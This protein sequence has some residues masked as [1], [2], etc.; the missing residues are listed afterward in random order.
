MQLSKYISDLLYRYECVIVPGFGGFVSNVVS[1]K[2]NHFT[3]TFYP[4]TKK[5][6]FNSQLQTNDG[7]LANYISVAEN[8]TFEIANEKINALVIAWK[9]QLENS[10]L[11]LSNIGELSLNKEGNI[12]FNPLTESNYLPSSFGLASYNSPAIKRES[13]KQ[14]AAVLQPVEERKSSHFF[15]YAAAV[16]VMLTVGTIGWK[17]NEKQMEALETEYQEV[18]TKKIQQATFIISNPLPE[19]N[20]DIVKTV[21]KNYHLI[22]GA[23][24]EE[25]NAFKKVKQLKAKGFNATIIGVNKWGL[26]QVAVDSYATREEAVKNL[27]EIK[28]KV[29]KDAWL[30]IDKK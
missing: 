10:S 30:F 18:V 12:L 4:P 15:K 20:L 2:A 27:A 28:I 23:F 6:S 25:A 24:G 22:V 29:S 17:A 7:L 26:T 8:C 3:H 5:L 1:S 21:T 13:Y 9:N 11:T 16:A 19:I 14:K